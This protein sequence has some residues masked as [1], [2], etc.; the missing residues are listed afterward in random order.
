MSITRYAP[1]CSSETT[2]SAAPGAPARSVR[3][4]IRTPVQC[5]FLLH[6]S[7]HAM[8]SSTSYWGS[9]A[10]SSRVSSYGRGPA[11]VSRQA[12]VSTR[13][14]PAAAAVRLTGRPSGPWSGW[15]G[16]SRSTSLSG[17]ND[18]PTVVTV[19]APTATASPVSSER[20]SGAFSG[21]RGNAR[22][23]AERCHQYALMSGHLTARCSSSAPVRSQPTAKWTGTKL[24]GHRYH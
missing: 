4:L 10:S 17:V 2:R 21:S 16:A 23:A 22:V 20:R 8:G 19:T 1:C 5:A 12:A 13:V 15:R 11:T 7:T 6:P 9:A 3:S 18:W 24:N 14:V